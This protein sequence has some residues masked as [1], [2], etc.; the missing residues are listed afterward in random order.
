MIE[1]QLFL[2]A[3]LT[4]ALRSATPLIFAG[5]GELLYERSGVI[6][7]GLEGFMLVGALT[8]VWAQ[9]TWE[10]TL[11]A[12]LLA[13]IVTSLFGLIHGLLCV[14]F[15]TNQIVTGLAFVFLLQGLT[16]SLGQSF[17]G[18]RVVTD[19]LIEIPVLSSIPV[20]GDVL[21]KQDIFVYIAMITVVLVWLFLFYTKWGIMLRAV[22]ESAKSSTMCG[23]PVLRIRLLASIAC[24]FLCG[25]GGAH[26]SLAY[27]SQ[28]QEDM[29]AGRG[30]IA[31]VMVIF[32]MWR[33]GFLLIGAC[34]FGGFS[35][36][37][38]NLQAQGTAIS[39]YYLSMVPFILTIAILSA[40]S[41]FVKRG[42]LGMPADLGNP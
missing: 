8:A 27:A 38:L 30:W 28:W 16:A 14:R 11:L 31:L 26:L 6:N 34:L 36:L 7:L 1:D 39:P 15:K 33:P 18:K 2:T 17:V 37:Q 35:T 9:V 20:L 24:G 40:A 21:F 13:A 32:A 42:G 25:V 10:N 4:G 19:L 22:G 23:L 12:V 29:I 5:L 41:H 3:V